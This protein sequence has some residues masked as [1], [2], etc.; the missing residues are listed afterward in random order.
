[1][2]GFVAIY[3]FMLAAGTLYRT[4]G[5]AYNR[6]PFDP[7]QVKLNPVGSLT[8][9]FTDASNGTLTWV[10]DGVQGTKTIRRLDF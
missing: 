4:S 6:L 8:L 10:V 9:N 3:I 7:G 5:P 1:M 2:D